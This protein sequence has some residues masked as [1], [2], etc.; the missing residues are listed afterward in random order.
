MVHLPAGMNSRLHELVYTAFPKMKQNHMTRARYPHHPK[1][2]QLLT[3][4]WVRIVTS[5]DDLYRIADQ[6]EQNRVFYKFGI[7]HDPMYRWF[8]LKLCSSY[9]NMYVYITRDGNES[10]T[11]EKNAV[12]VYRGKP[13]C[14]NA[15]PGGGS[16]SASSPHHFYLATRAEGGP[17]RKPPK[18]DRDHD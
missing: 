8:D 9:N 15:I 10:G 3:E 18:V 4:T 12:D 7:T 17:S 2:D 13:R 6:A 11:L 1:L 5:P 14:D 16:I